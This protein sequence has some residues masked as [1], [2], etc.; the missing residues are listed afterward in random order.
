MKTR[1]MLSSR[2][3]PS[4]AGRMTSLGLPARPSQALLQEACWYKG[5]HSCEQQPPT[6]PMLLLVAAAVRCVCRVAWRWG[7]LMRRGLA[8]LQRWCMVLWLTT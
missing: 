2:Q 4:P 7:S 8:S 6:K 5:K 1:T 3:D